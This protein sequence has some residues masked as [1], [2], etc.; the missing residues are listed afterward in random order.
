MTLQEVTPTD[1]PANV[2][3]SQT[4]SLSPE[5]NPPTFHQN[6]LHLQFIN[7]ELCSQ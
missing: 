7:H 3:H 5:G 2:S 1:C 6:N 4:G